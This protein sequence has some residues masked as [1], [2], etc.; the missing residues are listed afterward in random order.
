M[1]ST[2]RLPLKVMPKLPS[3]NSAQFG[4][5]VNVGVWVGEPVDVAVEVLVGVCV[6]VGVF[7][8]VGVRVWVKVLVG[9]KTPELGFQAFIR[10][11]RNDSTTPLWVDSRWVMT[12]F[13]LEG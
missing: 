5:A 11:V 12:Q 1:V 6:M 8:M 2:G 9:W 13:V 10:E 7:V 3:V 4:V